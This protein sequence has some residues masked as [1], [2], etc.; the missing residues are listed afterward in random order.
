MPK[1]N[2]E[3]KTSIYNMIE[4]ALL[5][6][7][8][9]YAISEDGLWYERNGEYAEISRPD[10]EE[11]IYITCYQPNDDSD[12]S[13]INEVFEFA[14]VYPNRENMTVFES[15]VDDSESPTIT[16]RVHDRLEEATGQ[17]DFVGEALR[18]GEQVLKTVE[19]HY[20]GN[21]I[22]DAERVSEIVKA[23]K[24]LQQE[25]VK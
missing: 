9:F 18:L 14:K 19:D 7:S 23:I 21:A 10:E 11:N 6:H 20:K 13:V 15:N 4:F 24:E 1:Q 5:T 17:P 3:T 2:T 8:N 12:D 22:A 16:F 25:R